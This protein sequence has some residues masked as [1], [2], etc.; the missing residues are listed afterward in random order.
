LGELVNEA[1]LLSLS[2]KTQ[3]RAV[4]PFRLTT[5]KGKGPAPGVVLNDNA[6]LLDRMEER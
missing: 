6:A 1:L 3:S 4:S 5:V 2:S